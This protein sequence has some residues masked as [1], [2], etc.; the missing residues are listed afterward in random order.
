[1]KL[2]TFQY[3]SKQYVG[4]VSDDLQSITPYQL[5]DEQALLGALPIIEMLADGKSLPLQGAP[6]AMKDVCLLAPLPRWRGRARKNQNRRDIDSSPKPIHSAIY[7]QSSA[8]D[9]FPRPHHL[10]RS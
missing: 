3:Q 4:V 7:R 5:S 6:I 10:A 9:A 2:A 8:R 1:M